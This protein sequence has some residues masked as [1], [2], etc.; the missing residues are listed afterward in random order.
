MV[1]TD[2]SA[3]VTAGASEDT[4]SRDT[5][6]DEGPPRPF[7]LESYADLLSFPPIRNTLASSPGTATP[8]IDAIV[9]PTIRSPEHLTSAVELAR[10]ARCQLIVL[11]T[12]DFPSGLAPVLARVKQDRVTLLALRSG[13]AHHLLDLAADLPQTQISAAALD[14]SRKRN[15]GLL[16]GR[17]C[18]WRRMLFLDD[19]IRSLSTMKLGSAASLLDQYPVA[20][21]QVS[22]YPD[23]SVVG[24]ARRL[25]RLAGRRQMLFI[26]GGSLLVNPQL[27]QGFF[28]PVYH[29]DWL[30][31]INHLKRG[32]VAIGGQV[33]QLN[34]QPFT[35]AQ[36]ARHEEFGEILASGLLWLVH[37]NKRTGS[38]V[39]SADD[40]EYWR[41]ATKESFWVEVL[42]QRAMLLDSIV[43]RLESTFQRDSEVSPLK[44]VEAAQLRLGELSPGEFVSFMEKWLVNLSLWRIKFANIRRSDSI[45]KAVI[46]LG[47]AH[48]VRTYEA[49]RGTVRSAVVR[50]LAEVRAASATRAGTAITGLVRKIRD[51]TVSGIHSGKAGEGETALPAWSAGHDRG[52]RLSRFVLSRGAGGRVQGPP[53]RADQAEYEDGGAAGGQQQPVGMGGR[54]EPGR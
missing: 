39:L 44:S 30:C 14:I 5:D 10:S 53:A 31:I 49:D 6:G 7:Q 45:A 46:E 28:P 32:E 21:L 29:E 52:P 34:Y 25:S 11:Y 40:H 20:G 16:I 26:S 22:S 23:A 15:L 13:A 50:R 4:G 51:A 33:G 42:A 35:T 17:A 37:A 1:C 38:T 19:D 2:G 8:V 24:H 9:V 54:H 43:E 41:R 36:R 48:V 27:L 18:G 12:H 3:L 47:L